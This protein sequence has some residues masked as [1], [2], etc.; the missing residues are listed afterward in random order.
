MSQTTGLPPEQVFNL[1]VA[2]ITEGKRVMA[3]GD[4]WRL[5]GL[6]KLYCVDLPPRAPGARGVGSRDLD[7][8]TEH[9]VMCAFTAFRATLEAALDEDGEETSCAIDSG[10]V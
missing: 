4:E 2:M 1:F 8:I 9:K 10:S 7:V 5:P 6:G 3:R